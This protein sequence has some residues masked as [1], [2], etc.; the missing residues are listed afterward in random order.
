[1]A[2]ITQTV[3]ETGDEHWC[4]NC[5]DWYSGLSKDEKVVYFDA[6]GDD[7]IIASDEFNVDDYTKTRRTAA[8][9]CEV[10]LDAG[11]DETIVDVV[12]GDPLWTCD[13]CT[14]VYPEEDMARNCC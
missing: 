13:E 2:D 1:M 14:A 8:C 7:I 3:Q 11:W 10:I 5:N 6:T 12:N 9:G 4:S